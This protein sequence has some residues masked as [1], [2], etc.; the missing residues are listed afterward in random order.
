MRLH[1][2]ANRL[3]DEWEQGDRKG[4][5]QEAEAICA[6]HGAPFANTV[7]AI[8]RWQIKVYVRDGIW[9][10]WRSKGSSYDDQA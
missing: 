6:E 3:I 9:P 10:E 7:R 5:Q 2:A 1:D 4:Y 8:A